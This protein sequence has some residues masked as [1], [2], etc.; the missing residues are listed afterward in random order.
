MDK[1]PELIDQ[2]VKIDCQNVWVIVPAYNESTRLGKTLES[3]C[4][5]Y[6][7]V[8]VVDDGSADSTNV[9]AQQFE[10]FLLRHMINCGQGAALQTGIE[11]ALQR[12]AEILVTYDADGQHCVEDI[13]SLLIPIRTR[14]IDIVFGSRFLGT[15]EGLPLARWIILKL[16]ILFTGLVSRIWMTDTHNGLRAFSR[17]A[18][19]KIRITLPGMSHASEILDQVRRHGLNYCEVPVTVKYNQETLGKGQNSWNSICI[20]I[21]L[22]LQ[23]IGRER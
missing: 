19:L 4:T 7:N 9:V 8:I 12:G 22:T 21:N 6:P 2:D 23:K 11:F 14:N 5:K 15:A 20:A 16:G 3:L 17:H 10:V 18:A 1:A 13:E